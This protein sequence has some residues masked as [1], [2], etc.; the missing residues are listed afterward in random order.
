MQDWDRTQNILVKLT[1]REKCLEFHRI[2]LLS[3]KPEDNLLE[4][5]CN[6]AVTKVIK[7]SSIKED[8]RLLFVRSCQFLGAI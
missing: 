4:E 5:P 7:M 8:C 2:S 1:I 3:I 6:A